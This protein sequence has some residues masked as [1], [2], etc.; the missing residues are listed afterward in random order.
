VSVALDRGPSAL[1]VRLVNYYKAQGTRLVLPL[2]QVHPW[3]GVDV[4]V[5][6]VGVHRDL[7]LDPNSFIRHNTLV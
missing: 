5:M 7:L 1:Y 6:K 4:G 3:A 2:S